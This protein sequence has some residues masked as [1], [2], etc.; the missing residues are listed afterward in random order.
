MNRYYPKN[1]YKHQIYPMILVIVSGTIVQ[2]ILTFLPFENKKNVIILLYI[3][4]VTLFSFSEIKIKNLTDCKYL[5]PYKIIT[6]ICL[7]GFTLTFIASLLFTFFGKDC[8]SQTKDINCYGAIPSYFSE[9][10]NK[11]NTDKTNFYLEIFIIT[12]FYLLIEF[13][14]ITFI[15]FIYK[16]LNPCFLLLSDNIYYFLILLIDFIIKEKYNDSES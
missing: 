10:K 12:P 3:F 16:Y 8:N 1:I 6:A 11:L 15:I 9:L 2:I 13:L 14:S 7:I 5:S 4:F